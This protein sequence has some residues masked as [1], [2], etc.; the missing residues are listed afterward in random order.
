MSTTH[1]IDRPVQ[2]RKCATCRE[3][4]LVAIDGG[5]D[6]AASPDAL[7]IRAEAAARITGLAI[8][9]LVKY[10]RRYSYL[11]YRNIWRMQRPR[12][13]IILAQ[14]QCPDGTRPHIPWET[15]DPS[16]LPPPK[17][18]RINTSITVPF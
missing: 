17:P 18:R 6:I 5:I 7:D 15:P 14:H 3:Y 9:D 11:R 4:V 1:L 16:K 8:V 10:D 13:G 2:G 12:T